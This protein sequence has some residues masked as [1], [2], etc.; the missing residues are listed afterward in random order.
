MERTILMLVL[1]FPVLVFA[2]EEEQV[3][4]TDESEK[5]NAYFVESSLH[6]SM[7][8]PIN[9]SKGSMES[10]FGLGLNALLGKDGFPLS[11]GFD[12][13]FHWHSQV[14][15]DAYFWNGYFDELHDLK[16]TSYSITGDI[17]IRGEPDLDFPVRPYADLFIGFNRLVTWSSI[18]GDSDYEDD[19]DLDNFDETYREQGDWTRAYGAAVGC[20]ISVYESEYPD[21]PKVY[22]N[23]RV[24]YRKGGAATYLARMDDYTIIDNTVEAYEERRSPTDMLMIQLGV[25]IKIQ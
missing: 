5:L 20:K 4:E 9:Q 10:G 3:Y 24:A 23:L 2:Q 21:E 11:G 18:E 15:A 6:F 19:P 14:N 12:F 8:L 25:N 7:G 22:V 13:G 17:L 1:L 16:T